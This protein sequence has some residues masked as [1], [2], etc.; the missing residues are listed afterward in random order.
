[1]LWGFFA[2]KFEMPLHEKAGEFMINGIRRSFAN[3]AE[4]R[5]GGKV[6]EAASILGAEPLDFSANVNPLGPPPLE[7]LILKEMKK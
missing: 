2:H 4:C 6:D 3:A 1:L 7:N 5:H